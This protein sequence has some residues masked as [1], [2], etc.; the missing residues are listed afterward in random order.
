MER[1]IKS[2]SIRS[3]NGNVIMPGFQVNTCKRSQTWTKCRNEAVSN[4]FN[5]NIVYLRAKGRVQ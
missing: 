4:D 2:I 5:M 1:Y 3:S